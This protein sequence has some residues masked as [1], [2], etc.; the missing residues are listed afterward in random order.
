MTKHILSKSTFISGWQCPK[1]LY[2]QK[3]KP[4]VVDE[5]DEQQ[6][7]VFQQGSDIGLLAQQLF[8]DGVNAQGD[9]EWHS[10]ITVERTQKLLPVQ[11]V[12][13]EAAFMHDGVLCALDILVRKGKKY[14]AFE[15]KGST[16]VKDYHI[17]DAALQY[18]VMNNCG[19]ELAD[20][21][22]LHLNSAYVRNGR[23][24]VNELFKATSILDEVKPKQPFIN[25][26]IAELK[27]LLAAK[28]EPELTMGK[29]CNKPFPC[30]FQNYC[31]SLVAVN[32]QEQILID[33]VTRFENDEVRS[34]LDQLEYPIYF[35]DFETVMY[36][37]PQYDLSSPYQQIP[38]QYSLHVQHKPGGQVSHHSYLGDGISDPRPALIEQL[39]NDLDKKG[40]ILVWNITFERG[41][42]QKLA[43]NFPKYSERIEAIINRMVDLMIPF[44]N[45]QVYNEA[46]YGSY[47][48]KAV[49]PVLV[50][51]LSYSD[52]TIQDGG[53][54]SYTYSQLAGMTKSEQSET[55]RQLLEYCHL[56]TLAMVEILQKMMAQI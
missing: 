38:F 4:E 25:E 10:S 42:L 54:A 28:Q 8:E 53:T 2:L 23:L 19:I 45:R 36:G 40:T 34:F 41:C 12:I 51:H 1:R 35:M 20:I 50:P 44:R 17:I 3:F 39:C 9:E 29:H 49:L 32:E 11:H 43:F 15:V 48:I 24:N 56:D 22:I 26:K 13:Y 16:K 52:L 46:F 5:E 7:A 55:R 6:A 33:A 31:S 18:H 30:N 37:V 21:S 14:Y 47:S 27:N